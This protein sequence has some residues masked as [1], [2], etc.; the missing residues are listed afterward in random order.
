MYA[1]NKAVFEIDDD[2]NHIYLY[3]TNNDKLTSK[4]IKIISMY[5]SLDIDNYDHIIDNLPNSL[6]KLHLGISFNQI[7]DNLPDSLKILI[8]GKFNEQDKFNKPVNNLPHLLE[9]LHIGCNFNY[10][11]NNLP[12]N[13][14][15]LKL[16]NKFN[17]TLNNLPCS[18]KILLIGS[19][20]NNNLDDLPNG[21]EKLI[22][23][24]L[25]F[26]EF[27]QLLNNLPNSLKYLEIKIN[28]KIQIMCP[29][30]I[31]ELHIYGDFEIIGKI[32]HC[33]KKI[34]I[35]SKFIDKIPTEYQKKCPL[36]CFSSVKKLKN[37][38]D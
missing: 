3:L 14:I 37:T 18:L 33:I 28:K 9:V 25:K 36:K 4:H 27:D 5:S 8:I 35:G 16:G 6:I 13:L 30:S 29:Y 20:F 32:H 19:E 24:G 26:S 12:N 11:L 22:I 23:G 31:E 21:L 38:M 34:N 15:E 7:V 10:K 17:Q 1:V 2:K